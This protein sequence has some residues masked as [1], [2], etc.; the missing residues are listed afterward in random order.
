[1]H[2]AALCLH[3]VLSVTGH[4]ATL[5]AELGVLKQAPPQRPTWLLRRRRAATVM[6]PRYTLN[7]GPL[8]C[9]PPSD[10]LAKHSTIETIA[11]MN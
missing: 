4:N 10:R 5:C 7:N 3:G 8:H 6:P 2:T 1:V 11:A 9:S